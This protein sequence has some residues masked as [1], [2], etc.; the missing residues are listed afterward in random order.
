[1]TKLEQ[2][3]KYAVQH[4]PPKR[5][6]SITVD[7]KCN[8]T[9][10]EKEF[11]STQLGDHAIYAKVSI[12]SGTKE[13]VAVGASDTDKSGAVYHALARLKLG[14]VTNPKQFALVAELVGKFIL[15][16]KKPNPNG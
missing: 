7:K 2:S 8:L 1:M 15:A 11:Y 5:Y 10:R 12:A 6:A 13:I 9:S 4:M 16:M 3:I 14:T